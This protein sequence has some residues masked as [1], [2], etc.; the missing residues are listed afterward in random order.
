MR[1]EF[2]AQYEEKVQS[3]KYIL[4]LNINDHQV[5]DALI[6]NMDETNTMFVPQMPRTRCKKG[7]SR[8]RLVGVG[9]DKAQ[10]MTTPTVNAEGDVVVPTQ[11]I[12]GGKTKRCHSNGGPKC[13]RIP[14]WVQYSCPTP[15][16]SRVGIS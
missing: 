1:D 7:T 4:S 15:M 2:P 13:W 16:I 14:A 12:F 11:V 9:K 8:V 3:F 6:L 10:V 5:P